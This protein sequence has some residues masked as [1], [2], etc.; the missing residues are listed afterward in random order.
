MLKYIHLTHK[1][2][3]S[4]SRHAK[5]DYLTPG[6]KLHFQQKDIF[7]ETGAFFGKRAFAVIHNGFAVQHHAM[8]FKESYMIAVG[9]E[10]KRWRLYLNYHYL[11]AD[12]LPRLNRNVTVQNVVLGLRYRLH[13]F[14][15]LL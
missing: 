1:K 11:K 10:W 5:T 12:E 7:W 3:N 15:R 6:F 14:T 2:S 13:K 4:F 9:K 8:E